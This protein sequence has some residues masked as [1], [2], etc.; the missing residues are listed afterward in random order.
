MRGSWIL[1][2][3]NIDKARPDLAV[4]MKS[5]V[6]PA[7]SDGLIMAGRINK[8]TDDFQTAAIE[9]ADAIRLADRNIDD[10][11]KGQLP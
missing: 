4:A 11:A 10:H 9:Y 5:D 3:G 1:W 7:D 6:Y 8:T 2:N